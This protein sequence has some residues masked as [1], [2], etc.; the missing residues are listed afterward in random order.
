MYYRFQEKIV[1]IVLL[2]FCIALLSAIVF[3]MV[4]T[5]ITRVFG[6]KVTTVYEAT[7]VDIK[8]DNAIVSWKDN[9]ISIPNES[10]VENKATVNIKD[11]KYV[12]KGDTLD[13]EVTEPGIFKKTFNQS[14]DKTIKVKDH[15]LNVFVL[16]K[17]F[18][19]EKIDDWR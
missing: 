13:I 16:M 12:K 7:V 4:K 17:R 1:K 15:N 3:S 14:E 19:E 8:G 9:L 10:F 6:D 2:L 18:V 5:Q 11:Y